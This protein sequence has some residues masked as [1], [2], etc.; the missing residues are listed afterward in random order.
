MA[1]FRVDLGNASL[2]VTHKVVRLTQKNPEGGLLEFLHLNLQQFARSTIKAWKTVLFTY[3]GQQRC[4]WHL[5]YD[6][7][8]QQADD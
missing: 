7:L 5:E 8:K 2:P 6:A 1:G 4:V 3:L